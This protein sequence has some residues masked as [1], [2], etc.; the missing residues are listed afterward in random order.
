[1]RSSWLLLCV[2][3]FTC[4]R[5]PAAKNQ[6]EQVDALL[7]KA[8][9]EQAQ[10]CSPKALALAEANQE[11][12]KLELQQGNFLRAEQHLA[13]AEPNAKKALKDSVG[14]ETREIAIQGP[15][16]KDQDRIPDLSDNCPENPEDYDDFEDTDGCPED[17]NDKDKIVDKDDQCAL[18]PE[19]YDNFE[20]TDGC[21]ED[22]N[23]KDGIVDKSDGC[24][25]DPEDKDNFEDADGCPEL[26]N[27][28]DKIADKDDKCPNEPETYN[29][30]EDTD[31]CP[32]F[33]LITI[34]DE[35]IVLTQKI[36]FAK[37]KTKILPKSFPLLDEVAE[38]LK[39]KTKITV[40]IEGHTSDE[41]TDAYNLKL[42]QGRADSVRQYLIDQGIDGA[43]M[44]A[45]GY[46]ESLPIESNKK[47]AGREKNRR[48]E[49]FITAQ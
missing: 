41:G 9:A 17:D 35:K 47:E 25:I 38:A 11:F 13:I 3:L 46:G 31:G 12:A 15:A 14:C 21:P 1:M 27:D 44:E 18:I 34:T 42:S 40:R 28:K 22:D 6:T 48:V 10:V 2:L 33:K 7:K 23:D 24:P 19:D 49:F 36:F 8:R 37:G 30:V 29:E 5:G 32:D 39:T 45:K 43:R 20:D 26:D 16:D 4:A